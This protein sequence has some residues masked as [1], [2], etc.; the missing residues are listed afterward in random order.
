MPSNFVKPKN[1][2]T[3][4]DPYFQREFKNDSNYGIGVAPA[5]Y[6]SRL[7]N[8]LL[9]PYGNNCIIKG[10]STSISYNGNI[11]SVLVNPGLA[12]VDLTLLELMASVTLDLDVI[13][14]PDTGYIAIVINYSYNTELVANKFRIKIRYISANGNTV[15]PNDWDI[16]KDNL[17][18]GVYKFYRNGTQTITNLIDE[19]RS[20]EWKEV[21]IK[22]KVYY[23]ANYN[24][25]VKN[26]VAYIDNNIISH[27]VVQENITNGYITLNT[28]P[29]SGKVV[30]VSIYHG[31]YLLNYNLILNDT[32]GEKADFAV[33]E[34]KLIIRNGSYASNTPGTPDF[35][36]TNKLTN[37]IQKDDI[38]F[39][40]YF[41]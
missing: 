4:L 18:L 13:G 7:L 3:I 27:R 36:L 16:E 35:I 23:V 33:F 15:Y 1:T 25:I 22:G 21:L 2:L 24:N 10:L 26:L 5:L 34:D 30:D 19:T 14:L 17:I 37:Q 9:K 12:I 6:L 38:L 20:S 41:F 29:Y 32:I 8:F 39:I 28:S 31:L 11:I 40:E